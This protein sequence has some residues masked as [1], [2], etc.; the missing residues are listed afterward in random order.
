MEAP[1]SRTDCRRMNAR[2]QR[3]CDRKAQST[4]VENGRRTIA[5][6]KL[7]VADGEPQYG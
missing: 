7:E 1:A 5:G 6:G 2:H 4:L 3:Q